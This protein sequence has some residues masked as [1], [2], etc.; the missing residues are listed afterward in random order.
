MSDISI[1]E[2]KE[3]LP[4]MDEAAL[5]AAVEG[6]KSSGLLKEAESKHKVLGKTYTI[7]DMFHTCLCILLATMEMQRLSLQ[8]VACCMGYGDFPIRF[9]EEGGEKETDP[10]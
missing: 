9:G 4:D 1:Y 5:T 6:L 7:Y 2:M 10:A 3:K 8:G